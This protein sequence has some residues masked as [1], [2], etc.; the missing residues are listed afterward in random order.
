MDDDYRVMSPGDRIILCTLLVSSAVIA[1]S[2]LYLLVRLV[3]W[4]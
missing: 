4:L 3:L 1:G 2:L